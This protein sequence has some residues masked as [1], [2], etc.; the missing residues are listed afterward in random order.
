MESNFDKL[1]KGDPI[2]VQKGLYTRLNRKDKTL[3]LSNGMKLDV[4]HRKD[5]F[6]ENEEQLS[7][8]KEKE[9]IK[10]QI[11][12]STLGKFG[13]QLGQSGLFGAA[14]D[15]VEKLTKTGDEYIKSKRARSE[16]SEKIREENPYTSLAATA[17]SFV[18]DLLVTRG[19]GAATAGATL[20]ALHA[21]PRIL[22][23][24]GE[25]AKEAAIGGGAG[26]LLGKATDWLGKVAARR[27]ASRQVA[28]EAADLPA[29]NQANREAVEL[30]NQGKMQQFNDL[31]N[32]VSRENEALLHQ[33]RLAK[34]GVQ[35]QNELTQR[36]YQEALQNLPTLQRQAQEQYGQKV[37][38]SAQDVGKAIP[39]GTRVTPRQL[40]VKEFIES[41]I[42]QG[43]LVG[44]PSARSAEKIL[45][46]LFPEGQ[47]IGA[48]ELVKRYESL[49]SAIARS[50]PE[51]ASMLT[52][53]KEH[54]A[55]QLPTAVADSVSFE[56]IFPSLKKKVEDTVEKT[57]RKLKLPPNGEINHDQI[58]KKAKE[59]VE[60]A[61][62][63][64][65][66][67]SFMTHL[68]SGDLE[69]MI[70]S[71][72]LSPE[73]F[74]SNFLK[75]AKVGKIK[76]HELGS[77]LSKTKDFNELERAYQ[78]FDEEMAQKL[79]SLL[80]QIEPR[81]AKVAEK[82]ASKLSGKLE[83]TLGSAEQITP[84]QAPSMQP[85]PSPPSLNPMPNS[86]SL[87]SFTPQ[88]A[89]TLPPAQGMTEGLGDLLEKNPF[90][91][92]G[93]VNNPLTKLAG[94]KYLL[95]KSALPVEAG[96]LALKGLTSPTAAGQAARLSFRQAGIEAIAQLAQKYPSYHDGILED[97]IERRSLTKEVEDD[98]EI[99]LEQKAMIQSKINRGKSIFDRL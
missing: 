82:S 21:G 6:P 75:L 55:D 24:P 5:L 58:L 23:E 70:R 14:K 43:N 95:G 10:G 33:N 35:A 52:Q 54:L 93:L 85:L 38:Q 90:G 88:E 34:E 32:Q 3:E 72:I 41:E 84:P 68:Q 80:Q 61:F 97:P 48:K 62:N 49:E 27:G 4:S 89:P 81:L 39:K 16:V 78:M 44:S 73:D 60:S 11:D 86:P 94:L 91:G 83:K 45:S 59:N 15:W 20:P 67:E 65:S 30:S 26:F 29:I 2:E 92:K 51:T 66:M 63:Q 7:H 53:F 9:K 8:E 50:T 17:T 22:E 13:F 37:V 31:R 64:L 69:K 71:S 25:V 76:Q 74:T 98:P 99:P 46:S 40:R 47:A 42:R 19:M 77:Y 12:R 1:R 18:P 96:Y 87:S 56:K 28:Q 79:P 36:Q 57:I